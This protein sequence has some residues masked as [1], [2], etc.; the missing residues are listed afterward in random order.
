[1]GLAEAWQQTFGETYTPVWRKEVC[2]YTFVGAHWTTG[3][4]KG[5]D[6]V[7]IP[8]GATWIT[9]NGATLDPSKP[10]FYL[11][12]APPKNTCLG[13]WHWGR[14]D[15]RITTA[16][17]S[18]PNAIAITGHSHA[19]ISDDRSIWQGAF[20]AI[21]AGSL[22]YTGLEYGDL[23]PAVRENDGTIAN[24]SGRIMSKI[25]RDDGH[26][27]LI[28]RGYDDPGDYEAKKAH[29]A[30]VQDFARRFREANG[31]IVCRELLK[32][33]EVAPGLTPEARTAEYYK[34]R[35]CPGLAYC[36]AKILEEMLR[37]EQDDGDSAE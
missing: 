23:L 1:L 27:G 10:F 28:A 12:H 22:K 36:A 37:E 34:K 21:N 15:G 24:N 17:S 8:E 33:V 11:Q 30:R 35:P 6:E 31:S 19:S 13:P 26:Q 3:G 20:T 32:G 16:L 18:F 14:D 5:Y 9:Q 7:G 29:Y 4:C 25:A 2:G